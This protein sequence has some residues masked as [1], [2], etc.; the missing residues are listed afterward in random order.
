[1]GGE[2]W[3]FTPDQIARVTDWQVLNVYVKPAVER[4][5]RMDRERPAP[6]NRMPVPD[7]EQEEA[8][9]PET[10]AMWAKMIFGGV[11]RI[12]KET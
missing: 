2:P 12:P 5:E 4:A 1:M 9:D 3:R 10:V 11:R 8:P 7:V 6:G